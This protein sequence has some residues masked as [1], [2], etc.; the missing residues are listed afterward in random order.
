MTGT[1]LAETL[2]QHAAWL[3]NAA[4]GRRANL[5]RADLRRANLRRANLCRADLR[6]AD[7][8]CADLRCADLRRANLWRADLRDADLR[9][10]DLW[11]AN[12]RRADLRRANLSHVKA[13]TNSA[14]WL[15]E[16]CKT[17]EIG[18]ICY[19]RFGETEYVQPWA[20]TP[21]L[22][23]EEVCN[24]LPVLDCACGINVGTLAWCEE[25]YTEAALWKCRIAWIDLAGTVVP[26][27]TDGKFRCSRLECIEEVAQ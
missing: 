20:P 1:E 11:R 10:A 17:D 6:D 25:N 3:E 12:L 16:Q 18:V 7:L 26:Y 15:R 19:K 27:N 9:R 24:L 23:I 21:G 22:I 13:L 14:D 5:C 4:K 8:R 2:K